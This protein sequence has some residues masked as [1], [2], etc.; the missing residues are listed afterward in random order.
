MNTLRSSQ[1]AKQNEKLVL[2]L[3]LL[4]YTNKLSSAFH[5]VAFYATDVFNSLDRPTAAFIAPIYKISPLNFYYVRF[6]LLSSASTP[7]DLKV[8]IPN[9]DYQTFLCPVSYYF[10][11]ITLAFIKC[12]D[13]VNSQS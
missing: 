9:Q 11:L 7:A 5:I 4:L 8:F 13:I 6:S 10:I 1:F 2:S 3:T 12:A